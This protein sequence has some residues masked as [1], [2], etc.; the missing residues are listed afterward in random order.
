MAPGD[1]QYAF[2]KVSNTSDFPW[3]TARDM[4]SLVQF[5]ARYE[6]PA[7]PIHSLLAVT[8]PDGM[9]FDIRDPALTTLLSEATGTAVR[10]LRLGRGCFDA[11]AISLLTTTTAASVERAH[12]G[13][14]AIERFRANLVIQP[15]DP[16]ATEQDWLGRSVVVGAQGAWLDAGLAIPRCAMIGIDHKTGERDP[17]IVRSVA[18]RFDN[19]VGAYCSVRRPGAVQVGDAVALTCGNNVQPMKLG[20]GHLTNPER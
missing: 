20:R 12:G 15:D 10:L 5:A 19:R 16:D 13:A 2:V 7:D 1:R 8:S 14:I 17:S 11:M 4:P 6:R 9:E 18:Q 3:L